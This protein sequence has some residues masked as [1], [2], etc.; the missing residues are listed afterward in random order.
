[1]Q[2][3]ADVLPPDAATAAPASSSGGPAID[4]ATLMF[5]VFIVAGGVVVLVVAAALGYR[6]RFRATQSTAV[7]PGPGEVGA[8]PPCPLSQDEW[9]SQ[10]SPS[11]G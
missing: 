4:E 3:R 2:V 11:C 8:C 10:F 7:F 9:G 6:Y 1:M 5:A